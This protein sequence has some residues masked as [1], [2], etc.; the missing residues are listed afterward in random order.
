MGI[1]ELE[2]LVEN[3]ERHSFYGAFVIDEKA[4]EIKVEVPEDIDIE[5]R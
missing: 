4:N 3:A 1:L 2:G 5:F